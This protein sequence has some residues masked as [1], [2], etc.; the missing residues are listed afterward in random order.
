M[1]I[2]RHITGKFRTYR[3]I[4]EGILLT[5]YLTIPWLSWNGTPLMRLDIPAR[6]FHFLGNIFI[7]QEGY[8]LHLF[9]IIAGLSLFFFTTLIGRVWCGWACPQTVF[10]DLFDFIG[11]LIQKE[12]YGKPSA[13]K[14]S[15]VLVH[16]VW[17]VVA[18]LSSFSIVAYF[19]DPK[20]M[21]LNALMFKADGLY[22]YFI[23][24]FTG[25]LYVDMAFVREQ[26][27]KYACPYARFQTVL[28]DDHSY[29]VTYDFKRGEPR[30]NKK[31]KIGDC[32]AC[33]MCLVVCPTGIDIREG[34]N[35]GCIACTKCI[36]ACT[37]QMAKENKKS[38]INY[39]SLDRVSKNEKIKW[40]RPRSILYGTLLLIA[41]TVAITLLI[42]RVPLYVSIQPERG[43]E[44]VLIDNNTTRNF[45]TMH[46][47]NLTYLPKN[48][49]FKMS[50]DS[51]VHKFLTDDSSKI[52]FEPDSATTTRVYIDSK[53]E[54]SEKPT[55][56]AKLLVEDLD[57]GKILTVN[58]IPI[59]RS[60][61][62]R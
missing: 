23:F 39:D 7:P 5:I 11:R 44:P 52:C 12:K 34:L 9:L 53:F 54:N 43:I 30:R 3:Y 56:F 15:T 24:F 60:Q 21:T 42:K 49:K 28:M 8:F 2:S 17:I 20:E 47:K 14:F 57:T 29:N 25:L 62:A 4:V 1:V 55:I 61:N 36:D 19:N 13:S 35:I 31:E 33:N 50:D 22:P 46:F 18:N 58:K 16:I 45:Y 38:L 59:R 32:T 48:I 51:G 37:I 10:T 6:K 26:F 27:C 41:G 40:I